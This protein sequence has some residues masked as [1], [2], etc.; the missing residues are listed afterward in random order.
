VLRCAKT[1]KDEIEEAKGAVRDVLD[2][3]NASL[4]LMEQISAFI[5]PTSTENRLFRDLKLI[6]S[7][8]L[9]LLDI[10]K[11]LSKIS[12]GLAYFKAE[13]RN[14]RK[15]NSHH[16]HAEYVEAWRYS[17]ALTNFDKALALPAPKAY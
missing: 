17:E 3:L 2:D 10:H 1:A 5:S 12:Q 13:I 4:Y 14:A 16:G 11:I 6:K 7:T 8:A 15:I 9:H